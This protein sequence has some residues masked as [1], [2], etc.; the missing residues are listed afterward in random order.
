MRK[1]S[2]F[3]PLVL[4]FIIASCTKKGAGALQE[5]ATTYFANQSDM[6]GFGKI[7]IGQI[8]TQSKIQDIPLAGAMVKEELD[9][10]KSSLD[11][12][13]YIYYGI[14]A[15][16]KN[17]YTVTAFASVKNVDSLTHYIK[18][19]G[20]TV[21]TKNKINIAEEEELLFAFDKDLIVLKAGKF[22]DK[23][24]F[25]KKFEE[26]KQAKGKENK[27]IV[28]ALKTKA[29]LVFSLF[30]DKAYDL[31]TLD[32][33]KNV[34]SNDLYKGVLQ[35]I[36]IQFNKGNITLTNTFMGDK[37]KVNKLN[38]INASNEASALKISGKDIVTLA[39][40]VDFARIEKE[41]KKIFEFLTNKLDNELAAK[42][43]PKKSDIIFA[44]IRKFITKENPL[45]SISNGVFYVTA[46]AN[47]ADFSKP[48]IKFYLGSSNSELKKYFK[49]LLTDWDKTAQINITD[50]AI[51]GT[52]YKTTEIN[53]TQSSGAGDHVFKL[54]IDMNYLTD[55]FDITDP[56][57][58]AYTKPLK[59][60]DIYSKE[61][62]TKLIINTNNPNTNA[63][64][65]LV[66][67]YAKAIIGG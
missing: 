43:E 63:L 3:L 51:E 9:G 40:N 60:I 54:F 15:K 42:E 49:T 47:K 20:Y 59:N 29:P 14:S 64:E 58:A 26:I 23:D 61:N 44:T 8:A 19:R 4:L 46:D 13:G 30:P 41:N 21:T 31:N 10:I 65:Y 24:N 52:I 34:V 48:Q 5:I 50:K 7:S 6:I 66:K 1:I 18:E 62:V 56:K 25:I 36:D 33:L 67:E 55:I 32:E 38:F 27:L 17:E 2:L 28:E 37:E 39:M 12:D 11:I 45:T 22:S 53:Y 57:T 35:T 16:E